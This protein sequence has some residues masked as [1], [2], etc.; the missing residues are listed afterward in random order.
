MKGSIANK[1]LLQ[2]MQ[3]SEFDVVSKE[4]FEQIS[5]PCPSTINKYMVEHII[6][7]CGCE[8]DATFGISGMFVV[9]KSELKS[10]NKY[11]EYYT[12]IDIEKHDFDKKRISLAK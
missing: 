2:S 3:Y 11:I 7:E 12:N 5:I 1:I 4:T 6:R 8:F 10:I 9:T